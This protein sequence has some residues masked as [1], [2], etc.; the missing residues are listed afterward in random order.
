MKT[1]VSSP[2]SSGDFF[3]VY[4]SSLREMPKLS[5]YDIVKLQSFDLSDFHAW[6][7]HVQLG[8]KEREIF[9]TVLSDFATTKENVEEFQWRKDEDFC[10]EY[11]L[12]SLNLRLALT[13]SDYKTAKEIW[14]QLNA[15]FQKEEV[16]SRTLL[17]ERLFNL[18]FNLNSAI[19]LQIIELENLRLKLADD[20]SDISDNLFVCLILSKLPPEWSTFKTEMHRL[21]EKIVLDELKRFIHIED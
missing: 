13:Y 20:K 19:T 7:L 5:S 1:R 12:N 14:V 8:M 18:R 3:L 21:K 6:K 17:G 4:Y 9:Y 10:R 16:L 11:L 15:N 2:R